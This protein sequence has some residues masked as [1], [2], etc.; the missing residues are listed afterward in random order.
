MKLVL[1]A[2]SFLFFSVVG[3]QADDFYIGGS[4]GG[5]KFDGIADTDTNQFGN[6]NRVPTELTINGLDLESTETAW[7]AY[8][9]WF[10]RKW[11]ALEIGYAD[12]GDSGRDNPEFF[13]LD[14]TT[15]IRS[16]ASLNVE[17]WYLGARF[18]APVSSKISANWLIGLTRASFETNGFL[19][20]LTGTGFFDAAIERIPF[21]SPKRETGLIWGF[22]FD[23]ALSERLALDIAY[24]KHDTQ[25]LYIDALTLGVIV[26]M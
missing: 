18:S 3:A 2:T 9:G 7:S 19:P 26:K 4:V 11:L 22:G 21:V 5:S 14:G 25:V 15:R 24:R 8:A 20:V 1:I 12:L 13:D 6:F 23:L 16:G 17:E 10:V